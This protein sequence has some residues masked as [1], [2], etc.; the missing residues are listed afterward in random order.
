MSHPQFH[1]EKKQIE[2]TTI[3]NAASSITTT[4]ATTTTSL[5]LL[6]LPKNINTNDDHLQHTTYN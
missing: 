6:L 5:L 2:L 3:M 4:T 1:A